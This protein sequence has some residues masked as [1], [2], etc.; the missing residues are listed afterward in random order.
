[1]QTGGFFANFHRT[2]GMTNLEK[3]GRIDVALVPGVIRA[4]EDFR[5]K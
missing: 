3:V 1:M 5:V 2:Q 4:D